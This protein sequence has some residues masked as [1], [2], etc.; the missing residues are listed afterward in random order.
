[1]RLLRDQLE[2]IEQT[3]DRFVVQEVPHNIIGSGFVFLGIVMAVAAIRQRSDQIGGKLL[4]GLACFWI[5]GLG[6]R[7]LVRSTI[8]I[9]RK[10]GILLVRRRFLGI[11][12]ERQYGAQNIERAFERKTLK[13]NSLRLELVGG[14]KKSLTLFTEYTSLAEQAGT[15]NHFIHGSRKCLLAHFPSK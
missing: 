12:L 9:D 10:S 2:I 6:L 1:M 13:G 11:D 3:K 14:R 15:L 4:V 5:L 7:G 8:S